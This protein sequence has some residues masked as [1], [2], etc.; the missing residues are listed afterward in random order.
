MPISSENEQMIALEDGLEEI[1]GEESIY[2]S[3]Y[4]ATG[5]DLKE[6][7]FY[8]S[9]REAFIENLN[10]TLSSHSSYPIEINF[11]KDEEWS[12]LTKLLEDFKGS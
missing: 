3:A 5:N 8:I 9:D 10:K 1:S 2:L 4:T 6:F 11:Y 7:I 12:D